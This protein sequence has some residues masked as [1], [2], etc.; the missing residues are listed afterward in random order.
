MESSFFTM[1]C[2]SVFF[3]QRSHAARV[4]QRLMVINFDQSG[5]RV[6][7][8]SVQWFV[9]PE[10]GI[11]TGQGKVTVTGTPGVYP[12][13]VRA[14]VGVPGPTGPVLK[15]LTASITIR[16]PLA[17]LTI[18]P[19]TPTAVVGRAIQLR[20]APYDANGVFLP[21]VSFRWNIVDQR[22]GTISTTGAFRVRGTPGTYSQAVHLQAIGRPR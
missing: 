15:E 2:R 9:A 11:S 21:D 6:A 13:A 22:A 10:V 5:K 3:S 7:N 12:N 8:P 17:S 19:D 1:S 16:G 18:L 20:A 14:V 4:V